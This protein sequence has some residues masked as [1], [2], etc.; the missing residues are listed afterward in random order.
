VTG[1]YI[2][3]EVRPDGSIRTGPSPLYI[4]DSESI[5]S[6]GGSDVA[7]VLIKRGYNR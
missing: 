2:K 4:I 3:E 7:Q 1:S 6:S 5:R